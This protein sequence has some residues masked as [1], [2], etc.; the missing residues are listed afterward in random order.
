MTV[1]LK[2]PSKKDYAKVI[3]KLDSFF[4]VR[5]N[6]IFERARFNRRCQKQDEPVDQF[7]TCLQAERMVKT[8]KK[9]LSMQR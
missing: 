9:W 8:V 6:V 2:P 4:Q 3:D 7:I 1:Q 5:K